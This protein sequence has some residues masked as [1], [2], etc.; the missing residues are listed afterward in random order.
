MELVL[1]FAVLFALGAV[2]GSLANWFADAACWTP[3]F[4]S[5]W[6]VLPPEFLDRIAPF[7][8]TWLDFVP[9]IGWLSLRRIGLQ[10]A[11]I[12]KKDR[13]P[14]LENQLFW[15]R[16]FLVELLAAL[17]TVGLFEWEVHWQMILPEDVMPELWGVVVLRFGI[18]LILFLFL[19]AATLTDFDDLIIPDTLTVYGTILGLSLAFG[20][21]QTL[22]PATEIQTTVVLNSSA[23]GK[24]PIENYQL[25]RIV[26]PQ[27]VPLHIYSPNP[28][29]FWD[30]NIA[31]IPIKS[32]ASMWGLWAFWC[33][34]MLDRIWYKKLPFRKAAAIFCRY[35]KRSP[36]TKIFILLAIVF[37]TALFLPI[38]IF[39]TG[40]HRYWPDFAP[41]YAALFSALVGMATG[42]VLIWSSRLIAGTVLGR[43]A[44]GFGDVTLMGLIGAFLGWQPCL[45]IF[46][47][48]PVAGLIFGIFHL[49]LGQSREMPYG[50][51][52]CLASAGLVIFWNPIWTYTEPIF[53]LGGFTIGCVMLVCFV[54]F[55]VLLGLWSWI[56]NRIFTS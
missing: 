32:F 34:A 3:R 44:M 8:K 45:L 29:S 11:A 21:P 35:L 30:K 23:T 10:L 53:E 15:L 2:L 33:F 37:P 18:H 1:I 51:F 17:G 24:N 47:M 4:R 7:S 26:S 5:P 54:M 25:R 36:R 39:S 9:I 27:A 49:F 52:L 43:E 38:I 14:G 28:P 6:R 46:F 31:G 16:P 19:L 20:L 12:R 41:R 55:G 48:A 22:L 40:E 13:L 56:R 50:P 42:M